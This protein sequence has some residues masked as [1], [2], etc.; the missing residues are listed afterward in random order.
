M[1]KNKTIALLVAILTLLV[2]HLAKPALAL[3]P[4]LYVVP[5]TITTPGDSTK[6]TLVTPLRA[7]GKLTV[8]CVA[9]GDEWYAS[10]DTG[11]THVQIWKFPDDFPGADTY[12]LGKY[13]VVADITMNVTKTIRWTTT[14]M[15][16]FFV[17]HDLPFG[18][19]MALVACFGAVV[20]Y[21]KLK[22]APE[23]R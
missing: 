1:Q 7:I 17:V 3:D 15:V 21:K 22:R 6:I 11:W 12:T 19:I 13:D 8:K 20:G 5:G 18:T 4:G 2:I 9:S 16:V 23:P 14:F 10:I